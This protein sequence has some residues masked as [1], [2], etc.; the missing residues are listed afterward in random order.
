MRKE[1]ELNPILESKEKNKI[2][3][4]NMAVI[5]G[6]SVVSLQN[7]SKRSFKQLLE[8][9]PLKTYY[10]LKKLGINLDKLNNN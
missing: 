2:T 6:L 8:T 9:T 1:E 10:K 5:S 3:W 7:L 4:F